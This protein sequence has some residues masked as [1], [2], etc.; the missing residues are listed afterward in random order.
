[1]A[2]TKARELDTIGRVGL[3]GQGDCIH[4]E[5]LGLTTLC[6]FHNR[7]MISD[8]QCSAK[9][10]P[11]SLHGN[12]TFGRLPRWTLLEEYSSHVPTPPRPPRP[13]APPPLCPP[14]LTSG[15]HCGDMCRRTLG[16]RW[17]IL[18]LVLRSWGGFC[19]ET[20]QAVALDN[21]GVTCPCSSRLPWELPYETALWELP[22]DNALALSTLMNTPRDVYRNVCV[23]IAECHNRIFVCT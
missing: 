2:H 16:T 7:I 15:P 20:S 5:G 9:S 3:F 13:L 10:K 17:K 8:S 11:I 12:Q 23:L 4:I 14:N 22:C 19:F 6:C 1:M 21:T 18:R